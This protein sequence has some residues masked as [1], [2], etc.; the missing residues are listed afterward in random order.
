MLY[1]CPQTNPGGI[2]CAFHC[3]TGLWCVLSRETANT[4]L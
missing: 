3:I 2:F 1:A 4:T